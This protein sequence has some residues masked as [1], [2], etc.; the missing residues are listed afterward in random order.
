VSPRALDP[1]RTLEDDRADM[2]IFRRR[3][4]QPRTA[5]IEVI[6]LLGRDRGAQLVPAVGES[7]YQPALEDVCGRRGQ[8]WTEVNCEVTALLVPEPSNP[9][10]SNAVM[11]TVSGRHV[12]YLSRSDAKSYADVIALAYELGA[13]PGCRAL[14]CGRDEGSETRNLGIFLDLAPPKK[15]SRTSSNQPQT[16]DQLG[17]VLRSHEAEP[18]VHAVSRER[19]ARARRLT[20]AACR[21]A[22]GRVMKQSRR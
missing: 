16:V 21:L 19:E 5:S 11:V 2:G 10:D 20:R 22:D 17:R 18:V 8:S 9:H 7:H 1:V 12:G 14:I 4:K 15:H 6:E 3:P 13:H